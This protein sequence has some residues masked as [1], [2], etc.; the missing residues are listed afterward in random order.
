MTPSSPNRKSPGN[1]DIKDRSKSSEKCGGRFAGG[2]RPLLIDIVICTYNNAAM[3][4]R[5][6]QRLVA[7]DASAI[8]WSVLVVETNCTDDTHHVIYHDL[9]APNI[10]LLT[11]FTT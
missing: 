7:Q 4:D 11:V 5:V 10:P 6:L 2:S 1:G 9:A 3:L 8:P